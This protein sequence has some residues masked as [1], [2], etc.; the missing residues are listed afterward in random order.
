MP[1]EYFKKAVFDN[2]PKKKGGKANS[3]GAAGNTS[4]LLDLLFVIVFVVSSKIFP[5]LKLSYMRS[6]DACTYLDIARNF[7]SGQGF[8][9]S[10]NAYQFWPGASYPA[11]PYIP[12]LYPL[13]ISL[14][15][16]F[17]PFFRTICLANVFIAVLNSILL[18]EILEM[19]FS[20]RRAALWSALLVSLVWPMQL[21]SFFPWAEQLHL[22]FLLAALFVYVKK[23]SDSRFFLAG[24]LVGLSCLVRVSGFFLVFLWPFAWM[25][26]AGW[27]AAL[28][29][30]LLFC[31]G[32][33]AV[34]LP[35]EIFC[36]VKYHVFFPEYPQA[37]K[38]FL[39]SLKEG[40]FYAQNKPVLRLPDKNSF[41]W[42]MFFYFFRNLAGCLRDF[43]SFCSFFLIIPLVFK[44]VCIFR[45]KHEQELLLWVTG[46]GYIVIFSLLFSWS[47]PLKLETERYLL[48]PVAMLIP[49]A[50]QGL[51]EFQR[52]LQERYAKNL[53]KA[54]L[55][56]M[57]FCLAWVSVLSF[58]NVI[59]VNLF[60]CHAQPL[61][62]LQE[63]ALKWMVERSTTGDIVATTL[64]QTA[65]D[66][67]RP[68]VSMP[69]GRALTERNLDLFFDIYR[70]AYVWI[71]RKG[72]PELKKFLDRQ[73]RRVELP[74]DLSEQYMIFKP[75]MR[76]K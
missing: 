4:H 16:L 32:I 2:V 50:V 51:W 13:F 17:F 31:A 26:S 76:R 6:S 15:G 23:S 14:L 61:E 67:G 71:A 75:N 68:V 39:L 10:Y 40:A 42:E 28:K 20:N 38:D 49:L 33:A 53:H 48:I 45:K 19:V 25:M 3:S 5:A 66:A 58:P 35:Y 54:F 7:M 18:Y 36:L 63:K 22:F 57:I 46:I 44:S 9:C 8:V 34:L 41:S 55:A 64:I 29:K 12:P 37:S 24:L 73:A 65:Y 30:S 11:W 60:Y 47:L 72:N 27:R 56:V 1:N 52:F 21:T 43:L 69:R 59:A 62:K 70:P 74:G